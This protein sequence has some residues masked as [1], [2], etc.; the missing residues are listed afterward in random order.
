VATLTCAEQTFT[1]TGLISGTPVWVNKPSAQTGLAL[2]GVR[3]SA[4]DTLAINYC[5]YS[6]TAI[7]PTTETYVVGNFQV[8]TPGAGNVV[9]Q[10]VVPSISATT[11]LANAIRSAFVTLGLLA[12]L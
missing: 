3:V 11:T 5:N 2:G 6:A 12:G 1:V 9:Y 10:T 8:K 7:V 4:T